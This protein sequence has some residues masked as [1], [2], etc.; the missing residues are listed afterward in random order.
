MFGSI[1][2]G[3]V[4]DVI[5][6]SL[7]YV[8]GVV[9]A[10]V[11]T[12]YSSIDHTIDDFAGNLIDDLGGQQI[13]G[14]V[15]HQQAKQA[16]RQ[17]MNTPFI[18]GWQWCIEADDA[19]HDMDIY[20]KDIDFGDGSIDADVFQIGCGSIA[21][22]T[23]SSCGEVSMTVRD[24]S[25]LRVSKWFDRQLAKVKNK[26]GTINLPAQYVFNLKVFTTTENG[27]KTLLSS[28]QVFAQ[29]KGNYSLT[30]EGVNTFMSVPLTFQKFSSV[31]DKTLTS[32]KGNS[33]GAVA[34]NIIDEGIDYA[35][36]FVTGLF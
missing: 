22:P 28:M 14:E 6:T 36:D 29:K 3:V 13:S 1:I 10:A 12:V 34:E 27:Q 16:A 35:T 2:N 18:Q 7:D 26:D 9:G 25:D 23:F 8:G 15:Y 19:P 17:L 11:D 4:D 33:L 30:R 32:G 5:D 21:L 24:H 31:G 20:V